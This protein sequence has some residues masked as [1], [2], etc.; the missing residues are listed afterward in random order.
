MFVVFWHSFV[1]APN[2][3]ENKYGSKNVLYALAYCVLILTLLANASIVMGYMQMRVE[4]FVCGPL[5]TL[6][7]WATVLVAFVLVSALVA[8]HP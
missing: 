3:R 7:S 8:E 6:F 4:L 1:F 2:W 5:L